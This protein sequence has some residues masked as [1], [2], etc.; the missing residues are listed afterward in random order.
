MDTLVILAVA[1]FLLAVTVLPYYRRTRRREEAAMA[2]GAVRYPEAQ[3]FLVAH[4]LDQATGTMGEVEPIPA[5]RYL[6]DR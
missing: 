6:L 1:L 3:G 4:E 2:F 5:W